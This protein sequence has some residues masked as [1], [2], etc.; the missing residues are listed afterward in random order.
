MGWE[1]GGGSGTPSKGACS[2][3]FA[4]LIAVPT[5]MIWLLVRLWRKK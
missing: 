1:W 3:D 5:A 2:K 4:L